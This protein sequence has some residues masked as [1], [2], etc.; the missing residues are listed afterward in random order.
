MGEIAALI[1]AVT[2]SC[3]SVALTSLSA[4]TSPVALS[5]LRLSAAT[6]AL[7]LVISATGNWGDVTAA[8]PLTILG[9]A[10]S[11]LLGYGLGDTVY[12]RALGVVGIQKTFPISM[13]LFIC[14]T[15]AGGVLLL[16]ESFKWALIAGAALIGAGIYLLA[17]PPG[18]DSA[19]ANRSRHHRISLEGYL[20]LGL[21]GVFWAGATLWLAQARGDLPPLA[22]GALRTPAG[23]IAL[24]GFGLATHP[25]DIIAPFRNRR[26]IGAIVAAGILGTTFGSLAYVYA[27]LEAGA[28]R[29]AVLSATS[30]LMALPLGVAFLGERITRRVGLGTVACVAG[31]LLVVV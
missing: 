23:A 22:A 21:V 19:T 14:L 25:R 20:L 15:V 6:L 27:V 8:P 11:G 7:P 30:P 10:G 13:A 29:T 1:A 9:V 28:A 2:W 16:D 5:A 17:V 24:L 3:T 12:I 31:I 26:H 4:R 18:G